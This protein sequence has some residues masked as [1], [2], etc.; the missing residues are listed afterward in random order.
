[1]ACTLKNLPNLLTEESLHRPM[2]PIG[3]L[4]LSWLQLRWAVMRLSCTFASVASHFSLTH[5]IQFSSTHRSHF[6]DFLAQDDLINDGSVIRR[7]CASSSSH[8][9][10]ITI[11]D[12]V[13]RIIRS[14]TITFKLGEQQ[15]PVFVHKAPIAALSD[16]LDALL[17]GRMVESQQG[18]VEWPDVTV[19]TFARFSN[20]AYSG[21]YANPEPTV[22]TLEELELGEMS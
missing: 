11:T 1:M 6:V 7:V 16:S 8:S 17:N 4:I 19:Q 3:A 20:F 5:S 12:D 21:D 13:D 18:V 15:E 2:S 22:V 10:S 9:L 14:P